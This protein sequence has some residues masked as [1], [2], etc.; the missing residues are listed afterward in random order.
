MSRWWK[1]IAISLLLHAAFVHLA[2]HWLHR[3]LEDL[4][5]TVTKQQTIIDAL[6]AHPAPYT[7]IAKPPELKAAYMKRG[8][9][10]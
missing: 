10:R 2:L 9:R 7:D 6:M 5:T 3:D 8:S 4:Q 1:F